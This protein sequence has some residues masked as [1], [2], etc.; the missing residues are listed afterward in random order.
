MRKEINNYA[1][2]DSQNLNLG[3]KSLGWK[4]DFKKFR[5]YLKDKYRVNKAYLFLGYIP[6]NQNM[7]RKLQEY[8]Y[9]LIFKPVLMNG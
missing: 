3:I 9:I 6:E 7:Y 1:F 8:G 5:I 2:I 4:L